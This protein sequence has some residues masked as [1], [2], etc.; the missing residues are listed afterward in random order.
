VAEKVAKLGLVRDYKKFLYYIDG[1]GS[2]TRK[3]K[4]AGGGETE[5][6]QHNVIE[7]EKGFL[8]Y[9]DKDGDISRSPMGRKS[10]V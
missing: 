10:K 5:V 1:S 6:V 9:I 2:V 3:P 8:Y 7:R 4:G